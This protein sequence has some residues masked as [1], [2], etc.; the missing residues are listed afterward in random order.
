MNRLSVEK[1]EVDL[2][3]KY[4]QHSLFNTKSGQSVP[5]IIFCKIIPVGDGD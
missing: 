1:G 4:R 2:S 5:T 3:G